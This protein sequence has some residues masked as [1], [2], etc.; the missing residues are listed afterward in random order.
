MI[1]PCIVVSFI[2][3]FPYTSTTGIPL[4]RH[5]VTFPPPVS[6]QRQSLVEKLRQRIHVSVDGV[7]AQLLQRVESALQTQNA[8]EVDRSVLE[9]TARTALCGNRREKLRGRGRS[10]PCRSPSTRCRR[11]SRACSECPGS[12]CGEEGRPGP[13]GSRRPCRRTWR[14]SRASPATGRGGSWE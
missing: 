11:P 13:W 2:S 12:R 7:D 8:Q 9:A 6:Y 5:T 10:G 14:R 4:L 1:P 3:C